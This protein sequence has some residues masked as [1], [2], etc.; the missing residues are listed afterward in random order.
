MAR[1][2]RS[3]ELENCTSRLEQPP[4]TKSYTVKLAPCIHLGY[5]RNT[6]ASGSWS[7]IVKREPEWI[8]L[9]L[10]LLLGRRPWETCISDTI[11]CDVPPGWLPAGQIADWLDAQAIRLALDRA[12]AA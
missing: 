3:N 10:H 1:R 6:K 8:Q 9:E 4:Q 7:V 5:R 2:I 12:I 11:G